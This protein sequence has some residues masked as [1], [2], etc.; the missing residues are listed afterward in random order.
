MGGEGLQK[1]DFHS[2]PPPPSFVHLRS[3][4]R[5]GG[6][7]TNLEDI[8]YQGSPTNS[9]QTEEA[10]WMSSKTF[11]PNKKEIHLS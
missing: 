3:L 1:S 11:Q 8:L 4:F 5:P 2:T 9:P 6:S 7:E 10:T